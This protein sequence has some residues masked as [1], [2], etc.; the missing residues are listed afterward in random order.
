MAF[1]YYLF[2]QDKELKPG[3]HVCKVNPVLLSSSDVETPQH[4]LHLSG[5]FRDCWGLKGQVSPLK[6][7]RG[8]RTSRSHSA[9]LSVSSDFPVLS[10]KASIDS[11]AQLGFFC[12]FLLLSFS[13]PLSS[14][15]LIQQLS[16]VNILHVN[17]HLR[18]CS[19]GVLPATPTI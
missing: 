12:Q 4:L 13:F 2:V 3:P 9:S 1:I 10:A 18:V 19:Q 11:T 5:P 15:D 8:L 16:A 7:V 14:T 6:Q 17:L